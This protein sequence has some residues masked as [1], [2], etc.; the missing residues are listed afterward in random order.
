MPPH[1]VTTLTPHIV[2]RGAERAIDF[3]RRALGAEEVL[4]LTSPDGAIAHAERRDG[5]ASLYLN[6]ESRAVDER[7]ELG[8]HDARVH[9]LRAGEGGKAALG[10]SNDVPAPDHLGIASDA[11]GHELGVFD[12]NSRV[13]YHPG[14]E[15][16]A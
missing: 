1:G 14:N 4:R 15:R 9:L 3:Y 13:A 5:D 16:L 12:Q 10:A 11:L 6:E 7:L 2:V 8:P